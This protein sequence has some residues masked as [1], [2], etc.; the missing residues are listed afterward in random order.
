MMLA[1]NT[2]PPQPN[3]EAQMQIYPIAANVLP[4]NWTPEV[5]I[6]SSLCEQMR[7]STYMNLLPTKP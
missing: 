5:P 7:I 6:S 2:P 1:K 3:T 4:Y